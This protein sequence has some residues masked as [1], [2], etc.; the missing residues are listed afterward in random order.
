MNRIHFQSAKIVEC[1]RSGAEENVHLTSHQGLRY[2]L[3]V[4]PLY[5]M[6]VCLATDLN[7]QDNKKAANPHD[8]EYYAF[9]DAATTPPAHPHTPVFHLSH[10]YPH[11]P[12][13]PLSTKCPESECPW[14][15]IKELDAAFS[16]NF[17]VNGAA[18]AAPKWH[19][20]WNEYMYDIL[21]Y[22]KSGQTSDLND[23]EGW[24]VE[25]GGHTRWFN[26]PWMAYDPTSGREYVHGTTNERTA[27]LSEL[28]GPKHSPQGR[29]MNGESEVCKEK[30]PW[31]FESWAVGYYN[32]YG[33]Y[34]V[35]RAISAAGVPQTA[36][37]LGTEIPAGLPF[38]EGT[39]V[40]KIL[41]TNAPLECVP[42][43]KGSPEWQIDRHVFTDAKG[44]S[45]ARAVQIS[46]IVQ[47][48]VAVSDSRSPIGWVYGTFVYDADVS[49]DTFW[50]HMVPVGLQW[51]SDPWTFPAVPL[52]SSLPVQQSVFNDDVETFQH[53]GCE[54]RLAG[55]VDNPNSSCTSCHAS[56]YALPRGVLTILGTNAPPSFG[57]KGMCKEFSQENANYF[58]NQIVPE[59]F[60]G[61]LFT[62]VVSMDTSLQLAL[63]FR[64]FGV[65]NTNHRPIECVD[66]NQI[67]PSP[68]RGAALAE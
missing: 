13:H 45:C 14:L 5:L 33:G 47:M 56:A 54:K 37:Y 62:S 57:F 25:V 61:G 22:V 29:R 38:P 9:R 34:V 18:V 12:P 36:Q 42:F 32:E 30:Y 68:R 6:C 8:A 52:G 41:T 58:Q 2:L 64:E 43:L 28:V 60:P 15:Y 35:G 59:A 10:G 26:V 48:D 19:E 46:R 50:D 44:Y 17:P 31:G 63:A 39:V 16:P 23:K 40:V 53:L 24:R 49:G 20:H 4:F 3:F 7:A 66:P 21:K 65:F 1:N 55:P 27:Q 51:G 67:K 11:S